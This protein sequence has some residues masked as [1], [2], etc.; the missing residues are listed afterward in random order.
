MI[1]AEPLHGRQNPAAGDHTPTL[2]LLPA[3]ATEICRQCAA[4]VCFD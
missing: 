1:F 3:V 4:F 2:E